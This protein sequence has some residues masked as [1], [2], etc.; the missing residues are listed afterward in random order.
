MKTYK[1][2]EQIIRDI[3]SAYRKIG[4]A[5]AIAQEHLDNEQLLVGS[6]SQLSELRKER[7]KADKQFRKIKR[8]ETVR[9]PKLKTRL[10][11]W[12]TPL[13]NGADDIALAKTP[14]PVPPTPPPP[15]AESD[16]VLP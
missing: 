15:S 7:E 1:T 16:D 11:E 4:N 14:A 2:R 9:L 12:D 10:A 5:K 3:D 6:P 13:L 8:L